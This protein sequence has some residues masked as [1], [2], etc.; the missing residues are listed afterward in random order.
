MVLRNIPRESTCLSLKIDHDNR[1]D[2]CKM[3]QA[4]IDEGRTVRSKK[5]CT[6]PWFKNANKSRRLTTTK[7]K[8]Q[9]ILANLEELGYKVEI[10]S[11]DDVTSKRFALQ[12]RAGEHSIYQQ[13]KRSQKITRLRTKIELIKLKTGRNKRLFSRGTLRQERKTITINERIDN[14]V[15]DNS[16]LCSR[17]E[18]R[19][20]VLPQSVS[21][22]QVLRDESNMSV[23]S[24][25]P[26]ADTSPPPPL[27]PVD[28]VTGPHPSQPVV[29]LAD[30]DLTTANSSS[31]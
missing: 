28:L 4:A 21:Q 31:S 26:A 25:A 19:P 30:A 29:D 3:K 15:G 1:C 27:P 24:G 2:A 9:S 16:G 13:K 10:A 14:I 22:A 12:E 7:L 23:A 11:Y 17:N 20:L 5:K 8:H 18:A 6:E